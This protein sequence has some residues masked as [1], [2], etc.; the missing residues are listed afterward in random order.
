VTAMMVSSGGTAPRPG[1][2]RAQQGPRRRA[3]GRESM[4][5]PP[6]MAQTY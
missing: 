6:E 1:L 4:A 3:A 5:A 2:D